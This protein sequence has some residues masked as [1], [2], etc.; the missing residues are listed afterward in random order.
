MM[1]GGRCPS[2]VRR[3]WTSRP[4]GPWS[5]EARE[6]RSALTT[7]QGRVDAVGR[8]RVADRL[9]DAGEEAWSGQDL[10]AQR[11]RAR[12]VAA[13]QAEPAAGVPVGY[14]GQQVQVVVDD[15]PSDRLAG[16]VDQPRAG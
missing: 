13:E 1:P 4:G 3:P 9:A 8:A 10:G 2:C 14:P 15:R 6:T 11:L 7:A 16:D 12:V 5:R